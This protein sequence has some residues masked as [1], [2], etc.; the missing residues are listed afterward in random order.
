MIDLY[1]VGVEDVDGV[2]VGFFL[3]FCM[4]GCVVYIVGFCSFVV[5]DVYVVDD[6]VV[7]KLYCE[8]C[9]FCNVY[10]VFLFVDGFEVVYD[11]F[12]FQFD[13]YVVVEYDLQW[14]V[15]DDVLLECFWCWVYD[16]VVVGVCYY[17]DVFVFV[18]DGVFVEFNG[19]VCQFLLV[20]FLVVVVMLVVVYWVVCVVFFQCVLCLVFRVVI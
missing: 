16:V 11:K 12:V 18:F 20:V 2:V 17:V 1:V 8:V 7:D 4:V 10:I 19:V 6:D 13:V 3:V 5:V 14:F 15:L 9:V